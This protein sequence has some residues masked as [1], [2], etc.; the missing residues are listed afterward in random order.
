MIAGKNDFSLI[1]RGLLLLKELSP[2]IL[3]RTLFQKI[4]I[5]LQPIFSV[6]MSGKILSAL[7]YGAEKERIVI[8]VSITI[9][10]NFLLS[11]L[12]DSVWEIN[13]NAEELLRDKVRIKLGGVG[14]LSSY[15]QIQNPHTRMLRNRI[16]EAMLAK[17]G[18]IDVLYRRGSFV[19]ENI[20]KVL[21]SGIMLLPLFYAG[22]VNGGDQIVSSLNKPWVGCM[23]LTIFLF[24]T[25]VA[26]R[27]FRN[28][29]A[30][31][32]NVWKE[33]PQTLTKAHYYVNEYT[34]D[35]GASKD[36]RLFSQYD[37]I[38]EELHKTFD[39]PRFAEERLRINRKND[40]IIVVIS[41]LLTGL[42]YFYTS[43]RVLG[44]AIE[45]GAM[46][47]YAGLLSQFVAGVT[48]VAA[49]WSKVIKNNEYLKELYEYLDMKNTGV[50]GGS[51]IPS[52]NSI[53][54][55]FVNVSYRYPGTDVNALEN[56]SFSLDG[57]LNYAIVGKNGSGKSTI[58][59]LLCRLLE[60][61]NGEI[62]LNGVN[63]RQYSREKYYDLI[64]TV[65][66][67][68]VLFA[69]SVA[70]N[71]SG[72][73]SGDREKVTECLQ[74]AG[75]RGLLEKWHDGIDTILFTD[76][77]S[78]GVDLSG[79]EAQK[80]AIARALYKDAPIMIL[81]EP[82]A[83][84]DPIAESQIYDTFSDLVENR[85]AIYISHRLSSCKF[86]DHILVFDEG[87]LVQQGNHD[88]L[89]VENGIYKELWEAQAEYYETREEDL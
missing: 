30:Q 56:V 64:S 28:A 17:R 6:F 62:L 12:I 11:F 38:S 81:D 50:K 20:C 7:S 31:L 35:N 85:M 48:G 63:I 16:D 24:S 74:K 58:I 55:D 49:E 69:A 19:F 14:L 84:L 40:A 82:T 83:A 43:L 10:V 25:A 73:P 53:H 42:V 23:V 87:K 1:S 41:T 65:F 68:F 72:G 37:M 77:S 57:H 15:E 51:L 70:D 33:W 76:L 80:I 88:I 61:T 59:K 3:A 52:F 13:A 32:F 34:G 22:Q 75:G 44:G 67:D 78:K 66:Q 18:G 60:P 2:G 9:G 21:I 8:L 54:I 89:K 86:C 5:A 71:I 39:R 36:I 26:Y 29:A 46:V 79:G 4:C 27:Q 45:I 47:T